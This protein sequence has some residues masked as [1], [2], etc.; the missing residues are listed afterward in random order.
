[1][2]AGSTTLPAFFAP[3]DGGEGPELAPVSCIATEALSIEYDP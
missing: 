3:A 2:R 1:M